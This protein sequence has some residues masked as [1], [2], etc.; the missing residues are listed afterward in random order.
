[1]TKEK[2][3]PIYSELQGYLSQAPEI[4]D[5]YGHSSDLSLIEQYNETIEELN[6]I[7]SK[8]YNRFKIKEKEIINR[9]ASSL[10]GGSFFRISTYRNKLGGLIARL[11][12]EY[13]PDEPAPFSGMPNTIIN[14]T[15]QQ[16][17]NFQVQML[18]E[19]QSKIDEKIPE[20]KEGTKEKS[21]LDRI[22]SL[23]PSIKNTTELLALILKTGKDFS[24]TIEQILNVLK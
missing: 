12:G 21:F 23:L 2:I 14:Q 16:S 7:S 10:G 11:Y 20:F 13:F 22:K 8:D 17:Q 3:R 9:S 19:M 4:K 1:M 5:A 15:Q 6:N 24:L 18:L